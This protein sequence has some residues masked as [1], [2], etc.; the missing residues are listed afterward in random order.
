M[1]IVTNRH[2]VM[3]IGGNTLCVMQY[4]ALLYH[5]IGALP[6]AISSI[7]LCW[8]HTKYHCRKALPV[9]SWQCIG[10]HQSVCIISSNPCIY[11]IYRT[12][13]FTQL[14]DSYILVKICILALYKSSEF[15]VIQEFMTAIFRFIFMF[16][17]SSNVPTK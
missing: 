7:F 9:L 1:C 2:K 5:P 17:V 4:D 14:I 10:Q 16:A 13:I 12:L 15:S 3:H 11:L 8:A 6:F